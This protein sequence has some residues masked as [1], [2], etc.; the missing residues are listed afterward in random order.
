MLNKLRRYWV[1]IQDK[2]IERIDA[3]YGV[4]EGRTFKLERFEAWLARSEIPWPRLESGRLDL[5]DNT[6]RQMARIYSGRVT[7]A[8]AT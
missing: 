1:P 5:S 4:F 2:L 7:I 6:F 8:G 3:D